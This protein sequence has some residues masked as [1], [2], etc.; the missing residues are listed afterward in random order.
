MKIAF[1]LRMVDDYSGQ[2]IRKKKFCFSIGNRVVHPIEKAEGLYVFLEPQPDDVRVWIEGTDYHSCSVSI[3][4]KLL[5]PEEPVADV[6]LYG[7]AGKGYSYSCGWLTGMLDKKEMQFPVQVCARKSRPTGLVLKECRQIEGEYWL[8]FQGFTR[9]NLLGK[10]Y[11]LES[12][13]QAVPFILAEKRGINEY[14]I[15]IEGEPPKWKAGT[16][17]ERIYRSVTDAYGAY[18]IPV[19]HGEEELIQEVMILQHRLPS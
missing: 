18:A 13:E 16:P 4:K 7:K 9:E 8:F 6:R 12:G 17:L 1:V 11:L 14:R 15:E 2:C 3:Q 5:N 19:D 10:P